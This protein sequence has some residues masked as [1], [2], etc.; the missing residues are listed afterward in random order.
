LVAPLAGKTLLPG[1]LEAHSHYFSSLTVANHL[2]VYAPLAGPGK[3]PTSIVA[4]LVK[5]RDEHEIPKGVVIQAYP[6]DENVMPN[7][8]GL[9]RDDLDK[10]LEFLSRKRII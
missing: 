6:Y 5:F 9:T 7:G 4:A 10:K 3:D 8:V 2:N 1:F